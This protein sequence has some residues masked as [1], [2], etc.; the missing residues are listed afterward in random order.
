MRSLLSYPSLAGAA[1][2]A[3][4]L[5][6]VRVQVGV[7]VVPLQAQVAVVRQV[8]VMV[9]M[10]QQRATAAR[11]PVRVAARQAAARCGDVVQ[12]RVPAARAP[13][14]AGAEAAAVVARS[15]AVAHGCCFFVGGRMDGCR[16]GDVC[17]SQFLRFGG[18]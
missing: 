3:A 17:G 8:A 6:V 5:V 2:S 7:L 16:M 1:P 10:V 11:R 18:F 15:A 4:V 13:G 9:V 12:R 14:G